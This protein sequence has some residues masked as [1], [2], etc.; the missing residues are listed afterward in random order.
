M[1]RFIR[2][3][4][5]H[6]ST[7]VYVVTSCIK[8]DHFEPVF[9]PEQELWPVHSKQ[10]SNFQPVSVL[11]D[12]T[13]QKAAENQSAVFKCR[14]QINYPEISLTWYKGTQKLDNSHKYEISSVGD[15]HCLKVKDCD[16]RDEG[17]YRVVCGPHVSSATLSV[18]GKVSLLVSSQL[19]SAAFCHIA[20]SWGRT[21][22]SSSAGS[23][24]CPTL[25]IHGKI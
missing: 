12:V 24:C 25:N 15:L 6:I 3:L 10:C 20:E 17:S 2:Q 14:I 4:E 5:S 21:C 22:W 9:S 23:R 8:V 18:A 16:S 1:A 19:I 13:D 11:E 7:Q